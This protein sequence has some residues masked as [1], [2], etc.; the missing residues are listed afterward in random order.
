M[1]VNGMTATAVNAW[2]Q[3]RLIIELKGA[4]AGT[5]KM[6]TTLHGSSSAPIAEYTGA[7]TDGVNLLVR[8]DLT[9]YVRTYG[10]S[11]F[12]AY[13]SYVISGTTYTKN[14][15]ITTRGRINPQGVI[16][17]NQRIASAGALIT[18]PTRLYIPDYD[19]TL[20]DLIEGEFYATNPNDWSINMH[21]SFAIG[22][23]FIGQFTGDTVVLTNSNAGVSATYTPIVVPC[24]VEYVFVRWVS[25][26]GITRCHIIPARK[27]TISTADAFSLLPIDNEFV[28]IKGRE[29]G[30]TLAMDGLNQYDLWYYA[31]IITSSKVE[32]SIDN[33]TTWDRVE[34]TDKS[35]TLPDGERTDGK[36][37]IQV[38]WKRYDAVAL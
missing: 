25:F 20:L 7:A 21:A 37:E 29:D 1:I 4:F 22:K 26:T 27:A 19:Q 33:G 34:I 15:Y 17:P 11:V 12:A 9:D 31:D 18:L 13:F 32:V 16:I 6:W 30:F 35:I 14:I 2:S 36:L 23:R 5:V 24:D 3:E 38:N 28:N 8:V 10:S